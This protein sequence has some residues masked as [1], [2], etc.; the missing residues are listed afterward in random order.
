MEIYKGTKVAD[1]PRKI[2]KFKSQYE[3]RTDKGSV[4]RLPTRWSEDLVKVMGCCWMQANMKTIGET[5][6]QWMWLW[7]FCD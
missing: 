2:S 4:G 5:Y 1:T 6:V 7:P 3:G